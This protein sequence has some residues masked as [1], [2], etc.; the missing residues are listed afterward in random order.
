MK[1]QR[2][3][4]IAMALDLLDREGIE[5]LSLRRLAAALNVQAPSLYWH[6]A[7][8]QAL[9]DAMADA[10]M[11]NVALSVPETTCW[12]QSWV[13]TAQE[14]RNA[15]KS[16]QDGARIFAG[17]WVPTENLLRVAETLA[18]PL[19][20][21]GTSIHTA[22]WGTFTLLH[23]ILGFVIEEQSWQQQFGA[24]NNQLSDKKT[25]FA[26]LAASRFPVMF[27]GMS[28]I[29][30]D[31]YDVRFQSGLEIVIAGIKAKLETEHQ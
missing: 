19:H 6:F 24:H 12:Q 1:I 16:R 4:I 31:D 22:T 27:L 10:L 29:F 21:T 5:A 9:I 28:A 2:A 3:T 8:K 11:N 30:A 13:L 18:A 14:I 7:S 23:Y 20:A 15:L 25:A 17:T 26:T